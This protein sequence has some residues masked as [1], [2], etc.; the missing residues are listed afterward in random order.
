MEMV[1]Q[2]FKDMEDWDALETPEGFCFYKA[3]GPE[4]FMAHFYAK[5]GKSF[6]FFK[7]VV[8]LG[9]TLGSEYISGNIYLNDHGS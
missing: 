6:E 3:E 4:L 5:K 2:Y 8:E 1:R 9:N 7:K